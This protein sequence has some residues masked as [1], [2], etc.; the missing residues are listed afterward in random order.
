VKLKPFYNLENDF[1][2]IIRNFTSIRPIQVEK[3]H[4]HKKDKSEV[5]HRKRAHSLR[6]GGQRVVRRGHRPEEWWPEQR[7]WGREEAVNRWRAAR[8]GRA[9]RVVVEWGGTWTSSTESAGKIVEVTAANSGDGARRGARVRADTGENGAHGAGSRHRGVHSKR[10]FWAA[11]AI[12][13]HGA[14]W[15]RYIPA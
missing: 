2:A 8:G 13:Q 12:R 5:R 10:G 3:Y 7:Q 9:V 15:V 14:D 6:S 4:E 11:A 1:T